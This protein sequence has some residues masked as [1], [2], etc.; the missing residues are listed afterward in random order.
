M[1]FPENCDMG[2]GGTE[3]KNPPLEKMLPICLKR[4]ILE[5]HDSFGVQAKRK[6]LNR[7][8]HMFFFPDFMEEGIFRHYYALNEFM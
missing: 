5:F 1:T 7:Q 4:L 8:F 2:F 3:K 6:I